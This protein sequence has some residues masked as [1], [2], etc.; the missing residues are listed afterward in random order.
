MKQSDTELDSNFE[1]FKG[2]KRKLSSQP[3]AA[4]FSKVDNRRNFNKL[5]QIK[6][7]A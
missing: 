7:E 6:R 2:R 4:K 5:R 1:P 3:T